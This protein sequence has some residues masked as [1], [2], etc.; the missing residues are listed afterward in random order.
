MQSTN[1]QTKKLTEE[2]RTRADLA[3]AIGHQGFVV[4][5]GTE[6]NG[7]LWNNTYYNGTKTF[8]ES[9]KGFITHNLGSNTDETKSFALM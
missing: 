5:E 9:K 2:C 7:H 3:I 6:A 1:T 8:V 4:F